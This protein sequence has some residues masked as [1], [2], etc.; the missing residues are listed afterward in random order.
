MSQAGQLLAQGLSNFGQGLH[1]RAVN[2]KNEFTAKRDALE[3]NFAQSL[4]VIKK[5]REQGQQPP[6]DLLKMV[7]GSVETLGRMDQA[8]GLQGFNRRQQLEIAMQTPSLDDAARTESE[9]KQRA[10]Y[11]A[12][13]ERQRLGTGAIVGASAGREAAAKSNAEVA[14][15][16]FNAR[17]VKEAGAAHAGALAAG[18][19]GTPELLGRQAGT[20]SAAET[21]AR[22]AGTDFGAIG[23]AEGLQQNERVRATDQTLAGEAD[24]TKELAGLELMASE[25]SE[26]TDVPKAE[27]LKSLKNLDEDTKNVT[28]L[29]LILE[30]LGYEP[31]DPVTPELLSQVTQKWRDFGGPFDFINMLNNDL[32]QQQ[33]RQQTPKT[34]EDFSKASVEDLINRSLN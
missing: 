10:E 9:R 15:T 19:L 13:L 28:R 31:G 7:M 2:K 26:K 17:A 32:Q 29:N 4:E 1:N 16:D 21:N 18:K 34:D 8:M 23:A 22:V 5:V 12:A 11:F 3:K 14:N 24:A 6:Q 20:Q 33:Q 30:S 27:I 25:L